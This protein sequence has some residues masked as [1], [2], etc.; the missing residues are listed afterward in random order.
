VEPYAE[1]SGGDV[2]GV[3]GGE[4][5]PEQEQIGVITSML[6]MIP[7]PFQSAAVSP[8]KRSGP[9]SPNKVSQ[10]DRGVPKLRI[11]GQG[12]L[13]SSSGSALNSP[14]AA[15]RPAAPLPTWTLRQSIFR[16]AAEKSRLSPDADTEDAP[17][18]ADHAEEK[19]EDQ[20]EE[21]KAESP[22]KFQSKLKAVDDEAVE[23]QV[24][25]SPP[26]TLPENWKPVKSAYS[27]MAWT[28]CH[29]IESVD[30]AIG[31]AETIYARDTEGILLV[32]RRALGDTVE[33]AR[34]NEEAAKKQARK[35]IRR[36]ALTG[37]VPGKRKSIEAAAAAKTGGAASGSGES[38][39]DPKAALNA[40][41]GKRAPPPSATASS[42]GDEAG[43]PK[44]KLNALFSKQPGG[45]GLKL[46]GPPVA[47][48]E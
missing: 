35:S 45:G 10:L 14:D 39:A 44:A 46:G 25:S 15:D 38:G 17:I 7:K 13:S 2:G 29:H 26:R 11:P 4:A 9:V 37:T 41:F 47:S 12:A 40:L 21:E 19:P 20:T 18:D 36:S 24:P 3:L 48:G 6:M 30:F 33:E 32:L 28:S 27:S 5:D 16:S 1:D 43:D 34:R 42:A 23:A 22:S 8:G 31:L